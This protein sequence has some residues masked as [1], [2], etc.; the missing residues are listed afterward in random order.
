MRH[1]KEFF[2]GLRGYPKAIKFIRRH[3]LWSFLVLPTL[4]NVLI[5]G[6]VFWLGWHYSND[7][8]DWLVA[9]AQWDI[10]PEWATTAL[11]WLILI[12]V[13]LLVVFIFLKT[14]T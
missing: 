12:V 6:G 5:L 10:L 3:Q 7:L 9:K 13:K 2:R 1:F 4:L 14:Y 11:D 8:I